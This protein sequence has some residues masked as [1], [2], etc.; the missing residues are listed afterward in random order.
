MSATNCV[1]MLMGAV[2]LLLISSVNGATPT[3]S[4]GNIS[5]AV[6]AAFFRIYYGQTFKVIKNGVDGKSYLLIQN[7]SRMAARTK[8]CTSRIKSILIPV[9]NYSIDTDTFPGIPVSFFELLGLLGTCKG[10]TSNAVASQC[11]VKL[12]E[13]GEITMVNKSEPQQWS[14]FSAFFTSDIDQTRACNVAN[15]LPSIED[16]PLQR[17][18]WIKYVGVFAN[19]E[20][21][22]NQVYDAVKENYMCLARVVA[23]KISSFKPIVAW[24]DFDNGVWSF[25]KE[26]YKLKF[27]EDA[28]G[29]NV[30]D[31]INKVTYN[32]SIP[33]D[34]DELHAI[35]CTVDAVID[36][37]YAPDPSIY[38]LNTL[39]Q[40][41]NIEDQSCF[42]FLTNQSV[43]RYDKKIQNSTSLDWFDGAVS[44][45]QLVLAD[46]IEAFFPAGNYTTTYFRNLAKGEEIT[47]NSTS[48]ICDADGSTALNPTLIPLC[49]GDRHNNTFQSSDGDAAIWVAIAEELVP[50][51]RQMLRSLKKLGYTRVSQVNGE[52]ERSCDGAAHFALRRW[53]FFKECPH[54]DESQRRQLARELGLEPRQI[55]FW[56][57]NKRTQTKTQIERADNTTLRAENERIKCENI[58]IKE[59]LKAVICPSCGG[60]PFAED[61]RLCSIQTLQQEN[62]RLKQEHKKVSNLLAKYMGRPIPQPLVDLSH[63][64]LAGQRTRSPY[65][66]L[67][68]PV[69]VDA[70][71]PEFCYQIR[72]FSETEKSLMAEIAASALDE[73]IKLLRMDEPLWLKSEIDGRCF[74]HHQG[75]EQIF[76]GAIYFK[77]PHTRMES[78]KNLGLVAMNGKQLVDILLDSDKWADIFPTFIS[79]ASTVQVLEAGLLG[80]RSGSLQ[81]INEKMHILSPLIPPR[82]F[83]VLRYC[84]QI[85]IGIWVIVEIS[86]D[87]FNDNPSIYVSRSWKHPSGCMIEDLSNGLSKV[88]WVEHVEID[89]DRIHQLYRDFVTRSLAFGAERWIVTLQRMCERNA[90]FIMASAPGHE[91]GGV[92]TASEGR[93][94]MIML[95]CRMIKSFGSMLSMPDTVDSHQLPDNGVRV[96]VRRSTDPGRPT[97]FVIS[98]CS[99]LWLPAAPCTVFN[100][101]MDHKMRPQWDVLSNGNPVQEITHIPTGIFPGNRI[102]VLRPFNP[103]ENM[104]IFQE[105]L[106]DPLGSM[107]VYAR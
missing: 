82:E 76:P 46:L 44:Q 29:E 91:F 32:I 86:Y 34:L 17:A 16:S 47:S 22:A 45:P 13:G 67:D 102:S 39:L 20:V 7:N 60:T 77:Y 51:H 54:P 35:L 25:T 50:Y 31:S 55:K 93:K 74:L 92:T 49:D 40:N 68:L 28:G 6:D 9:S 10:I 90:Y 11:L 83:S 19:L 89:D 21:R 5:K 105:S 23:S 62:T 42:A 59:A 84:Q 24:M 100:Y 48:E 12:Y 4:A 27:V 72:K 87:C 14:K 88:T 64:S 70:D 56:F 104:L 103:S 65:L 61:E 66:D 85:E 53:R 3:V 52:C 101:L 78:S 18:E 33:E 58:A 95:A 80:S 26:A 98:A 2:W 106:I 75:Y 41:I 69:N 30:D 94:S 97:G 43:W 63:G 79:D 107:I 73:L 71:N 38:T 96:A 37:T 1:Q 8:Y 57:Q 36:G 15:F 81:L 99:C